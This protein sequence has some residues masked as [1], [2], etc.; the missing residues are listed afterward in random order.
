M[1]KLLYELKLPQDI[2][3]LKGEDLTKLCE[4]TRELI[5]LTTL[6]NGGH[7]ASNL[8]IVEL[9]VALLKV[10]DPL[11][12]RIL[13]DVGHQCYA[14]KILTDRRDRFDKLRLFG[15]IS[16][17][18]N[19]KESVYDKLVAG[20]AG[21]A[22]G[23]ALGY[24]IA[25]SLSNKK[26]ENITVI[27]DGAFSNGNHLE[28]FNSVKLFGKQII[29]VNDNGY[30]ISP[31]FGSYSDL[32]KSLRGEKADKID[33][34]ILSDYGV[35]YIGCVDGN[36]VNAL[37]DVLTLAK[38][39]D[40]SVIVHIHTRKG[41]GYSLSEED[42]IG[43]HS[44]A[45]YSIESD[46]GFSDEVGECLYELMAN[47]DKVVVITPAMGEGNGLNRIKENFKDRFID[48]GI[49]EGLSLSVACGLARAGFKPIIAVY[50]TFLQRAYDQLITE[51]IDLPIVIISSRT[52]I[53]SGDGET[54][55]GIYSYPT[56]AP[57]RFIMAY[58]SG[59]E[60]FKDVLVWAIS[61][62]SPVAI[63][64][65]KGDYSFIAKDKNYPLWE[66]HKG[67]ASKAVLL[68]VGAVCLKNG[69]LAKELLNF[70]D[71]DID[72]VNV[73]FPHCI[74]RR[75]IELCEGK[76]VYSLEEC[77]P[78]NGFSAFISADIHID[79]SFGVKS[80]VTQGTLSE[81][82][83]EHGLSAGEIYKRI[84]KDL[85]EEEDEDED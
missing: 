54:H 15:G 18:P 3:S 1:G 35:G 5:L 58:P 82:L 76:R 46:V 61:G 68:C 11:N 6:K 12:D 8:G 65:P 66:I 78:T 41:L 26:H 4:E 73:R 16:G 10:F 80:P 71:I 43:K 2:S 22:L 42:P 75:V 37:I 30:S 72:I 63:N 48:V 32:F 47:N 20:H 57:S 53:V 38:E 60:E 85:L 67:I 28:A 7:L 24:S 50:A 9:T 27:G 40:K 77:N 62:N 49:A 74:D 36:D 45:G 21:T 29:V 70:S 44:V 81:L 52:G 79:Y 17:F 33:W 14:Y 59:K 39:C 13:F 31:S 23:E 56:L 69:F 34:S 55:Q 19:P 83:Y 84:K 64:V 25:D 51:V